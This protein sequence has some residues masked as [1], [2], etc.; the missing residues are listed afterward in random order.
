[1]GQLKTSIANNDFKWATLF[2]RCFFAVIVFVQHHI[3]FK[4]INEFYPQKICRENGIKSVE[5][6]QIELICL[7]KRK[8]IKRFLL[9][10][11]R[12]SGIIDLI[13][14]RTQKTTHFPFENAVKHCLLI[15]IHCFT[16]TKIYCGFFPSFQLIFTCVCFF[17]SLAFLSLWKMNKV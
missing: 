13:M 17:F 9:E 12:R 1:M 16:E 10:F 5:R 11:N 6:W 14:W 2:C 8:K 3:L 15:K 7:K 4:F